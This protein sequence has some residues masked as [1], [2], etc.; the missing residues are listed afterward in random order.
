MPDSHHISAQGRAL[1][2]ALQPERPAI[3]LAHDP[4]WFAFVPAGPHLTLSG[5]THGGQ[6]RLPLVGA[7]R[8]ASRAPLRWSYGL[9]VEQGRHLYVTGGLGTSLIPLRIGMPPEYAVI[10]VSD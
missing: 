4:E 9:V 8:N 7:L 3:V 6:V 10:D 5:H 1:L 2:A